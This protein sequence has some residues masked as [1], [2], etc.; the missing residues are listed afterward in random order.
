[1][2]NLK[3]ILANVD[4]YKPSDF[5]T[6]KCSEIQ[7]KKF[8]DYV[9]LILKAEDKKE[10]TLLFRGTKKQILKSKL[11]SKLNSN[12]SLFDGLF[13]VGDKAKKYLKKDKEIPHPIKA[14]N[15]AGQKTADWIFEEYKSLGAKIIGTEYFQYATNRNHFADEIKNSLFLVDYYLIRLHTWNSDLLVNFVSAT[16]DYS[17]ASSNGNDMII[18]LFMSKDYSKHVF[19]ASS[20]NQQEKVLTAKK[21]PVI[22]ILF[23]EEQE[24]S[25]KGFILPH[26]ILGAYSKKENKL[27]INPALLDNNNFDWIQN[28]FEIDNEKFSHFIKT[29]RYKRFLTLYGNEKF[30]EKTFAS[31]V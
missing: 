1:M 7:I 16:S 4:F 21:L 29:T 2:L 15:S 13:L 8:W 26:F 9:D 25:F 30:E 14:I 12:N 3:E 11:I 23:E 5:D 27:I 20:L 24:Y 31:N 10:A 19:K 17:N 18:I 6:E 28:G 22:K